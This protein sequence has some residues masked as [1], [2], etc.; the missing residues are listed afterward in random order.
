M[1]KM[2]TQYSFKLNSVILFIH[3]TFFKLL[4]FEA[5]LKC[6]QRKSLFGHFGAVISYLATRGNTSFVYL[7]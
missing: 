2:F 7:K 3:F 6:N 4:S 1:R 5:L